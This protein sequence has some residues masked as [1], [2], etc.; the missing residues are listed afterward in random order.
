LLLL[1][2]SLFGAHWVGWWLMSGCGDCAG[3]L[4]VYHA[5]AV[6]LGACFILGVVLL[7]SGFALAAWKASGRLLGRGK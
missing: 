7:A 3:H 1:S 6:L 5:G 2:L 4:F